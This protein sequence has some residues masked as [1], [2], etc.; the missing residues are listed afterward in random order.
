LLSIL[1]APFSVADSPPFAA[2]MQRKVTEITQ[3][4][5]PK[6]ESRLATGMIKREV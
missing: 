2:K 5:A 4:R 6:K 1:N 3:M